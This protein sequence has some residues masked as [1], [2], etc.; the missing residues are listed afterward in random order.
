MTDPA[1]RPTRAEYSPFAHLTAPNAPLYRQVTGAFLAAKDRFAVH[2]RPEDVHAALPADQRPEAEA[3]VQALD[4]LVEWGNLRSD[5]DTARV[6]AVED[7]YRKR[8]IYQL[9][10][11]GEAA[12]AALGTFDEA[13]GRRGE[14]QAVALHDIVTQL[15]ALLVIASEGDPDPSKAHLALDALTGRF[16]AL[17]ENAR[18]FMGSLQRTIDLHDVEVDAFLAYKDRLIQY[19]ERFI[20]DLITLGGRIAALIGELES[21][22]RV[23]PL[24]RL[25]AAREATDAVPEEAELAEAAAHERW[26][27]RWSGLTR[28][29]VSGEGRESQARLLRGRALGGIRQLLAVVRQLNE[30]R[31]GRSD[32]SADFRT[33]ARWFAEAPDDAARHRLWRVAFGLYSSRHLTVDADTLAQRTAEPVPAATPWA[34]AE[35]LRISPQLRRTGS[36][37]RRGKPRRVADRGAARARLA[38][39]AAR[40]AEQTAQAR[41]RLVTQGELRLSQLSEFDP[42][43]FE[44]FLRLLGDALATW[45]PGMT[46]TYA[47]SGDGSLDIRLTA[48]DDGST[49]EIHTP[50][51]MFRGPD[52][53][54]EITDLSSDRPALRAEGRPRG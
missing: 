24:L 15:R 1:E 32:R 2:L 41:R 3:L 19:L 31:S 52:H 5:P 42:R 22:G 46:T 16:S 44:L 50:A 39:I 36:Y 28:W 48:L 34:A 51:G 38:E 14:L 13:L 8:F 25:A 10:R 23:Q 17:A 6:T 30:R 49:A 26:S 53:L 35:P 9:T 47:T 40:E 12:E 54:V 27:A 4:R 29:F 37:E 21:Q 11:E 43:A 18:V 33:L 45:R 20:Q 7:F